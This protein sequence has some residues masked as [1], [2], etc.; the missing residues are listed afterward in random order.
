MT[1]V[2]GF[3]ERIKRILSVSTPRAYPKTC[4]AGIL[5]ADRMLALL[6]GEVLR[7]IRLIRYKNPLTV[8]H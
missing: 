3:W 5:P 8:T 1:A 4:S 7:V 2:S 6:F